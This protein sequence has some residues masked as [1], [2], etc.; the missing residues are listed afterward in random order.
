[1]GHM[2]AVRLR[3]AAVLAITWALA[4]GIVG[5]LLAVISFVVSGASFGDQAPIVQVFFGAIAQA[6]ILGAVCG[7]LFSLFLAL[8]GRG[9]KV[10]SLAGSRVALIG[11]MAS[12]WL[13]FLFQYYDA[14]VVHS[15]WG[16][17]VV[18]LGAGIFGVA[19]S[20]LTLAA[21]RRAPIQF[22]ESSDNE[23]LGLPN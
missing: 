7:G 1:M 23:Q 18:I 8:L 22:T 15:L 14:V 2:L 11:G 20:W 19:S 16:V 4:W 3:A 10:T 9:G 13:A 5:A 12:V 6:M 21:A 17:G